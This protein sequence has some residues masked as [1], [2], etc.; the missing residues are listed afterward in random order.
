MVRL[1]LEGVKVLD[2][3]RALSGPLCTMLLGDL[4]A[5]VV[6]VEPTPKGDMMRGWGP[7]VQ[8]Q[9]VYFLSANRN[10]QSVALAYRHPKGLEALRRMAEASDLLV[11]NFRPGVTEEMGIGYETLSQ[12]RPQLIYCSISGY[13]RTGPYR[14][15]PGVDQMAQGLAGLMSV[16]GR[17]DTGPIRAGIP[18]ADVLAGV[19]GAFG[20]VGAY[21]QKLRSGRGARVDTSLV[22]ALLG[23]MTFQAQRYLSLGEVSGPQGN[24]HPLIAPYGTFEA[25][26]GALNMAALTDDM[27]LRLCQ[28]LGATQ[29]ASDPRFANNATR[30]AHREELKPLL[31][32]RLRQRTKAEWTAVLNAEGIPTA[33]IYQMD[34]VFKDPNIEASGI[35]QSAVHPKLGK[36]NI[37]GSPVQLDGIRQPL[38]LPPPILGQHTIEVLGGFGFSRE[39]IQQ[40]ETQGAIYQAADLRSQKGER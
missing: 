32:E 5:Q 2:L 6:K 11:E 9:S 16:T 15:W 37:V 39:E 14:D 7:F 18:I 40:L 17:D 19:F 10:K 8:E 22:D 1:P 24:D 31:N 20:V 26:D 3:T 27:W 25:Q 35:V 21:V 12:A 4:G 29:E 23:V 28:L 30:M 34:E 38:R 13:G 33:P 36:T